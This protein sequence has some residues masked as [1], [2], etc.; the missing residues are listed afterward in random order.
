MNTLPGTPPRS[1]AALS[2]LVTR[3]TQQFPSDVFQR[4]NA[5]PMRLRLEARHQLCEARIHSNGHLFFTL[6]IT[7]YEDA[8]AQKLVELLQLD[9]EQTSAI[10]F[11]MLF[12]DALDRNL[13]FHGNGASIQT[14]IRIS[15]E[16]KTRETM[17]CTCGKIKS[18]EI[19]IL[20]SLSLPITG[21]KSLTQACEKYCRPELWVYNVLFCFLRTCFR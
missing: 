9:N 2:T 18:S 14:V 21:F 19:T 6:Q 3:V 7:P 5:P 4:S 10:E 17:S 16:G 12:F 8:S 1:L 20:R 15:Y 11:T 13:E